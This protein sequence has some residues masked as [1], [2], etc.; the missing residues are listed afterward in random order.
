MALQA[1]VIV[2]GAVLLVVLAA[3]LASRMGSEL[4]APGRLDEGDIAM[5][6]P[7]P[8]TSLTQAVGMQEQLEAAVRELP[9]VSHIVA[10]IGTADIW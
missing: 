7:I 1:A 6:P 10:K 4:A 9:E 5:H 2:A 3:L 8:G